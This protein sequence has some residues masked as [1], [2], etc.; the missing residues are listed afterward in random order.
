VVLAGARSRAGADPR[1]VAAAGVTIVEPARATE[2][3]AGHDV[4]VHLDP[5]VLDPAV[6]A[7][8]FPEPGGLRLEELATLLRSVAERARVVGIE[9]TALHAPE[10]TPEVADVLSAC[11]TPRHSGGAA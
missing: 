6:Y 8:E 5:D 10:R 9:A 1:R 4:Y 11:T 2:R 3:L 7:G